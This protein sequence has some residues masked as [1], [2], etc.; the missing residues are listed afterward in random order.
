MARKITTSP[1]AAA[2]GF[3]SEQVRHIPRILYHW[4]KGAGSAAAEANAKPYAIAAARRALTEHLERLHLAG[5]VEPC[6]EN[7]EAH[8]VVYAMSKPAPLVTIIIPTRDRVELLR[9]CLES[10]RTRT[11]YRPYEII[12]VDNGSTETATLEY[13]ASLTSAADVRV[14]PVPGVFN[15]SRLNNLAAAEAAGEIL[16]FLNN[17]IEVT[18]AGWLTELVSQAARPEVGAAGAR[19]WYADGTLQHGGVILGLGGVAGHAELRLPRGHP[20]YFSRAILQKSVSALTGACL[21][22]RREIFHDLGG[23]NQER[24]GVNFNDIDYCLRV[25][26]RG[27]RVVWT[28]AANLL[29]DESASRGHHR[30]PEEQAQFFREAT[31]MQETHGAALLR[32]PFYNPNL[33]LELPGYELADPPRLPGS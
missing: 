28:P 17:D 21:A 12:V 4:R 32:D 7:S 18:E 31:Y 22:T 5:R 6:P 27:L 30:S 14:L 2:N 24:L 9:R 20:G 8:R 3:A 23:F 26:A 15:F 10:L 25:A 1:C 19:L 11:A 13:L 16:V 33:S 29:H